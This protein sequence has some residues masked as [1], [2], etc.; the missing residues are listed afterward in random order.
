MYLNNAKIGALKTVNIIVL[1]VVA[2]PSL[3]HL[4]CTV[5]VFSPQARG[6]NPLGLLIFASFF[7]TLFCGGV[8]IIIWRVRAMNRL[9]RARIYNSL[10]EE[11]HDG[12]L[13]YESIASMTGQPV[14]KVVN[15]LMF[16]SN[17]N[18]L[19]NLTMGRTAVRVDLL[20]PNNEFLTVVCPHCGAHVNIR[21]GGGGR[22]DHCGTFMRAK[23]A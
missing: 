15:D 7:F 10:F 6:M 21:K 14:K 9:S 13:T 3:F 2:V 22:C 4:F 11:D 8:G 23:E 16:Y 17:S 20:S 19:I 5:F 1:I 12:I 18:I